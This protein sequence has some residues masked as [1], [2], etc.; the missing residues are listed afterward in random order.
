MSNGQ[1][2][3]VVSTQRI[4]FGDWDVLD[5]ASCW[6]FLGAMFEPNP[7]IL[8]QRNESLESMTHLLAFWLLHYSNTFF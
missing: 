4:R 1:D 3:L 6:S 5:S 2:F 7:Q 8:L